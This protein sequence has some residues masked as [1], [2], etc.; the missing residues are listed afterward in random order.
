M[1]RLEFTRKIRAAIIARANGKCEACSA[2]LKPGEGDVDHILPDALQG[3]P[4]A[5]NG[6]WICKP[7]HK[8]KTADD[9]KR[10]RKSDRQR[11]KNSGAIK[12]EG[13]LKS[14]AFPKSAKD[15]RATKPPLPPRQLFQRITP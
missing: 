8:I 5:A 11:D 6:R 10:I 3:K 7:C 4:T 13:R 12:P 9:I 15:A 2:V 14:P 1:A